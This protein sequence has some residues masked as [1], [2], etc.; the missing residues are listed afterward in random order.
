MDFTEFA[1]IFDVAAP[2]VPKPSDSNND[3]GFLHLD[4]VNVTILIFIILGVVAFLFFCCT[5]YSRHQ[6]N[7]R[8]QNAG[9]I[10]PTRSS[11]VH[12]PHAVPATVSSPVQ[13]AYNPSYNPNPSYEPHGTYAVPPAR[14][15]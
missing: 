10:A 8:L 5:C 3:N 6:R 11:S 9:G 4:T 13:R 15:S 7:K 14:R 2:Y 12:M 1:A